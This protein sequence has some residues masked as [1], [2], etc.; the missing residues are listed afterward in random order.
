MAA[1]DVLII[2][3]RALT[4]Q[5]QIAEWRDELD[6]FVERGG[7]LIILAQDAAVWNAQ[8]LWKEMR[9]TP[10]PLFDPETPLHVEANHALLTYPNP[11][12]STDWQDWLFARA[13]NVVTLSATNGMEIPLRAAPGGEPLL[14]TTKKGQ[15]RM[16][17]VD[18][19]LSPQ[20][21]NV[22]AGAFRLL[23]NLISQ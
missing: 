1:L 7:H 19:A 10:T 15:G 5:P 16:T 12:A 14:V 20:L 2:D 22:H 11:T 23:A 18:L 21:M 17:Y 13:Y 6:Q 8:P 3:R 4:L 9:L